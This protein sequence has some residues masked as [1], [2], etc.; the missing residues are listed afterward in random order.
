VVRLVSGATED[1]MGVEVRPPSSVSSFDRRALVALAVLV[2]ALAVPYAFMGPGFIVDDWRFLARGELGGPFSAPPPWM[3]LRRPGSWVVVGLLHGL[4]GAHPLTIFMVQTL[5]NVAVVSALYLVARRF[6]SPPVAVALAGVWAIL[7]NHTTL[8]YWP[9]TANATLALLLLIVGVGLLDARRWT[10]AG[11]VL[12]ASALCYEATILPGVVAI[13]AVPGFRHRLRIRPTLALLVALAVTASWM[14]LHPTYPLDQPLASPHPIWPAHFGAGIAT[15]NLAGRLLSVLALAGLALLAWRLLRRTT[16]LGEN[17][18]LVIVGLVLIPL[19]VAAFAKRHFDVIGI[20]DRAYTVS[21]VGAAMVWVGLAATA[22]AYSRRLAAGA[23]ALFVLLVMP[24]NLDR[25]RA[26][27][28]AGADALA[29]VAYVQHRYGDDI[30]AVVVGPTPRRFDGVPGTLGVYHA[31]RLLQF[32]VGSES[33]EMRVS[34]SAEEFYSIPADR[35]VTWEE[36][37]AY[38]GR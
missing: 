2:L 37:D 15:S 26:Y 31:S 34:T 27:S 21:A 4:I 13:L 20:A 10:G 24:A 1:A 38:R 11:V 33:V 3:L 29:L 23:G 12:V 18:W 5:L 28:R 17:E 35:R 6:V 36:V 30:P 32:H 7:P 19:G 8:S 9:A 14:A 16:R 25:Q 22:R